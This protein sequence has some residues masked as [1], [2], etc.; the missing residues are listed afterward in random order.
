MT[1]RNAYNTLLQT[2][3]GSPLLMTPETVNVWQHIEGFERLP[4]L[5]GAA[6]GPEA[7]RVYGLFADGVPSVA[8]AVYVPEGGVRVAIADAGAVA[9][10]FPLQAATRSSVGAQTWALDEGVFVD[11]ALTLPSASF[12][13]TLAGCG[14]VEAPVVGGGNQAFSVLYG[15]DA[16][17]NANWNI[18]TV[19][20]NSGFFYQ[21]DLGVP[22]VPD[23]P[24]RLTILFE[25]SDGPTGT[26]ARI[27]INGRQVGGLFDAPPAPYISF[28]SVAVAGLV[29]GPPAYEAIFHGLRVGRKFRP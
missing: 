2:G 28:P 15:P 4:V 24:T 27:L 23:V 8:T 21:L 14:A 16:F 3:L 10:V 1:Q 26:G 13:V 29:P 7:N 11:A 19:D 6:G 17:G 5:N 9:I 12:P 22:V 20:T 25:A 18:E